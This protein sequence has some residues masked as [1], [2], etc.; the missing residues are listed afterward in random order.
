[1]KSLIRILVIGNTICPG[2][3]EGLTL[4]SYWICFFD[5]LSYL[6]TFDIVGIHNVLL[7]GDRGTLPTSEML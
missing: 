3:Q 4:N 1:M 2:N 7:Q 5:F 6:A